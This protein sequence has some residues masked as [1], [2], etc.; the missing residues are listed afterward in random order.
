MPR[1]T[2][3]T[4]DFVA[5]IRP[6]VKASKRSA[7]SDV[8]FSY[9][10]GDLVLSCA[11]VE[12]S[13]PASGD[14][15]GTASTHKS[16]LGLL[17][18]LKGKAMEV[19]FTDDGR[20]HVGPMSFDAR[21]LEGTSP[22]VDLALEPTLLQLLRLR[23]T[24]SDESLLAAGLLERVLRAERE[25]DRHIESAAHRLEDLGDFRSAINTLV[26]DSVERPVSRQEAR[27]IAEQHLTPP[28]TGIAQVLAFDELQGRR[29]NLYNVSGESLQDCWIAYV[30]RPLRGLFSS[31]I[32]VISRRTG[33]VI[34]NGS[35]N[36]E[37]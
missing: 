36:D 35:A 37:G 30:E 34:Y 19:A 7:A 26:R 32:I 33:R 8:T 25:R 14:W 10:R 9:S 11:G 16:V 31:S 6:M 15:H 13:A 1:L 17:V 28:G 2:L 24:H 27:A 3:E 5:A 4:S 22:Q 20:L 18:K 12:V 21:W 29:V 23:F